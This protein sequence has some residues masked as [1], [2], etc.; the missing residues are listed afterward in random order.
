MD[1]ETKEFKRKLY[2][3][4][5]EKFLEW[6]AVMAIAVEYR[7]A[8]DKPHAEDLTCESQSGYVN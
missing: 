6:L 8:L 4:P 7:A 3:M 2:E 5:E 1:Q